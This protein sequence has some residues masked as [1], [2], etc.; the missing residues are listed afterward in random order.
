MD[1]KDDVSK[2]VEK[3]KTYEAY[4]KFLKAKDAH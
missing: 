1:D 2:E 4:Y 3:I